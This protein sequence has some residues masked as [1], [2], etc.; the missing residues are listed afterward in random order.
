M[1]P[2]PERPR[3]RLRRE[4][5]SPRTSSRRPS[6]RSTGRGA[7]APAE[8]VAET[9]PRGRRDRSR[10]SPAQAEWMVESWPA[11]CEQ[12]TTLGH[13]EAARRSCVERSCASWASSRSTCRWTP[14]ALRA[15]P[16][17]APFDWERRGQG[18]R[19]RDVGAAATR[20]RPF[21]DP[22]RPHRRGEPRA[23]RRSGAS[24]IRSAPN[25]E[26]DWMV[27]AR[28][29]RHEVWARRDPGSGAGSA[30][31]RGS[32]RTPRSRSSR[33][34]RRSAAATGRCRRCSRATRPTP[35]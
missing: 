5:R 3:R 12:P 11:S 17:A 34:S 20:R 13:E 8:P 26:D 19:G 15:H 16:L 14:S 24:T 7:I 33:W 23:A 4:P 30:V 10:R 25:V 22:E 32:R 6:S 31:A 28:C 21:A 35:P 27:R 9:A 2:V 1:E 18:E 29:R